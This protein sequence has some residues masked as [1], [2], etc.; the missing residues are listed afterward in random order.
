[1]RLGEGVAHGG[2]SRG[3]EAMAHC[4]RAV[5]SGRIRLPTHH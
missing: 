3:N 4:G 5:I 2:A 1:L